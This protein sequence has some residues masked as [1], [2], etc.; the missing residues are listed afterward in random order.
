MKMYR[1]FRADAG[2]DCTLLGVEHAMRIRPSSILSKCWP[3]R[4][5]RSTERLRATTRKWCE[6]QTESLSDTCITF[7]QVEEKRESGDSVLTMSH[8]LGDRKGASR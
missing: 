7:R 3:I 1:V 6:R 5:Q 4:M 2:G 8:L